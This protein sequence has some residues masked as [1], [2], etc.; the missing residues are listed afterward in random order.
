MGIDRE[1]C[2]G[3]AAGGSRVERATVVGDQSPHEP[4]ADETIA[5]IDLWRSGDAQAAREV[6]ERYRVRLVRFAT[7]ILPGWLQQRLGPEDVVQSVFRSFFVGLRQGEF[8]FERSADLWFMLM[9]MTRKKLQKRVEFHL[10]GKRTP[11]RE[12]TRA[13]KEDSVDALAAPEEHTEELVAMADELRFVLESLDPRGRRV[14]ELRLQDFDYERIACELH[15]STRTV[16][17]D[18]DRIYRV[19]TERLRAVS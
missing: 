9:A 18:L 17:R 15:T 6:H 14:L 11:K 7:A 10:A 4:T 1:C 13:N 5:L 3:P 12:V 16:R 2:S 19:L 8:H